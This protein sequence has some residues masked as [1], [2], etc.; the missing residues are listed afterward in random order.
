M[1]EDDL[2]ECRAA[3]KQLDLTGSGRLSIEDL[4]LARQR[5]LLRLAPK[6]RRRQLK[7]VREALS[8]PNFQERLEAA[9]PYWAQARGDE[10]E[11]EAAAGAEPEAEEAEGEGELP[12]AGL[13]EQLA[14]QPDPPWQWPKGMSLLN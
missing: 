2:L 4:E 14:S 11:A 12:A 5:K 10:A 1:S 6:L 7:R 13:A 3:F 8:V 9:F